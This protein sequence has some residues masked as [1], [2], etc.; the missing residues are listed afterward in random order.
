MAARLFAFFLLQILQNITVP[1]TIGIYP[2][3]SS[4]S[5]YFPPLYCTPGSGSFTP[6]PPPP[7]PQC[8]QLRPTLLHLVII[9]FEHP[10]FL[11]MSVSKHN[12]P[13]ADGAPGFVK[14]KKK[15]KKTCLWCKCNYSGWLLSPRYRSYRQVLPLIYTEG[16]GLFFRLRLVANVTLRMQHMAL[17]FLFQA[18]REKVLHVRAISSGQCS[19]SRNGIALQVAKKI[20][21][22]F[23]FC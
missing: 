3:S 16:N 21:S 23:T 4:I 6:P 19:I 2:H 11:C 9:N 8:S 20:A 1:D 13:G 10:Y 22:H 14:K 17:C 18:N 12:L 15:K 5:V 7:C